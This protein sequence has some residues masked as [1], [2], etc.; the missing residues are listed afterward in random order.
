[1]KEVSVFVGEGE[2]ALMWRIFAH[3]GCLP[4]RWAKTTWRWAT[5][6]ARDKGAR[7]RGS[8]EGSAP[9]HLDSITQNEVLFFD[10][11]PE[12]LAV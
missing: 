5:R 3:H 9:L 10:A 4:W 1:M 2:V 11:L 8:T 6:S 7:E 12:L